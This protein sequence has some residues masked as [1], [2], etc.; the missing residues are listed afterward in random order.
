MLN[1]FVKLIFFCRHPYRILTLPLD[2][3]TLTP[4]ELEAREKAKLAARSRVYVEEEGLEEDNWDE[5][6]YRNL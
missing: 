1:I 3:S 5:D 4:E 6:R 2:L